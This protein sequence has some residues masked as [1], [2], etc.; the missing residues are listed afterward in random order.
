[1][2][3]TGR[4]TAWSM[5]DGYYQELT[6]YKRMFRM[7]FFSKQAEAVLMILKAEF[8]FVFPYIVEFH[9]Q[10]KTIQNKFKVAE[11]LIFASAPSGRLGETH[12]DKNLTKALECLLVAATFLNVLEARKGMLQPKRE[13]P[14]MAMRKYGD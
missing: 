6:E 5:G 2:Y 11:K 1:M 9:E 10:T 8:T 4:E 12:K 14:T 7:L 13:D 3:K